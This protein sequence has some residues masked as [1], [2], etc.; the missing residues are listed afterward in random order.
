M[1]CNFFSKPEFLFFASVSLLRILHIFV[2]LKIN[3]TIKDRLKNTERITLL[4]GIRKSKLYDKITRVNNTTKQT[5]AAFSKSVI[6][7]SH[8]LNSTLHPMVEFGGGG[9]NRMVCQLVD[10]IFLNCKKKK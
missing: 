5:M 4:I 9:L 8:G 2:D 10:C 6:W 1:S 3:Q 7:T